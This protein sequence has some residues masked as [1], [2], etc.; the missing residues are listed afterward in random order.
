MTGY[1]HP[2]YAASLAEFGDPYELRQCGGWILR[3][4]IPGFPDHDAI[5]CYPMFACQNW[6]QLHLDLESLKRELVSLA[7]VTD[8]FGAYDTGY[9]Q[10]CFDVVVPFKEHYVADLHQPIDVIVSKHHRYYALKALRQIIVEE[11]P[12][13]SQFLIEWMKLYMILIERYN[14]KGIKAFSKAAFAKQLSIPGTILFLAFYQGALVGADWYYCQNEVCYAHLVAIRAE[15][16]QIRASYALKWTAINYFIGK[17]R[18]LHW[19]AGAGLESSNDDGLSQFKRGWSTTTRPVYFC[20]R[21]FDPE[22]YAAIT[23]A[24]GIS[25]SS[26]FPAYRSGEFS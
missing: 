19:G 9:L 15:G 22:R 25:A 13:P 12:D 3:R 20:A 14:L 10:Q 7:L 24:K 1:L 8:P 2:D 5:G 17:A 6:S 26:Y 18:W 16:Y 4:P 23:Y 21:I 11:C